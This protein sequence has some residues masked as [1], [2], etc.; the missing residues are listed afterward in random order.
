[1]D[2]REVTTTFAY[3]DGKSMLWNI[4]RQDGFLAI[5]NYQHNEFLYADTIKYADNQRRS[6]FT[7]IP[8]TGETSGYVWDVLCSLKT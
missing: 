6:V 2:R 8:N 7:W 5:Q 3:S 4:Y 1:M